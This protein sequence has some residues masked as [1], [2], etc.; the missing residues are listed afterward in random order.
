[1]A[2][3]APLGPEHP[4]S[5]ETPWPT[6]RRLDA[7]LVLPL[8]DAHGDFALPAPPSIRTAAGRAASSALP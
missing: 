1:M 5:P 4:S 7:V 8:N 6:V 3:P 2:G